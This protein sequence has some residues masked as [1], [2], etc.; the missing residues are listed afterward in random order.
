MVIARTGRRIDLNL[1]SIG[2]KSTDPHPGAGRPRT[3]D[4][5][6]A[7]EAALVVF[8]KKGYEGASLPVLTEAMGMQRPSVYAIFGNKEALFRRALDHYSSTRLA[9]FAQALQQPTAREVTHALLTGFACLGTTPGCP[10][11]C[12]AVNSAL[13]CS[14]AAEPIRQEL[15][16]R[17]RGR[18]GALTKRFDHARAGGDLATDISPADLARCVMSLAQGMNVQA[19]SG[20]TR[21]ELLRVADLAAASLFGSTPVRAQRAAPT[22]WAGRKA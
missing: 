22:K 9:F 21:A 20:A 7:L 18:L 12:L 3:F 8:W 14:E 13:A 1:V 19:A 4:A 10:A 2:M 6:A 15:V 11:G 16:A 17:R 5:D